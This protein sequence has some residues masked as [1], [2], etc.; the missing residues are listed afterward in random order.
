M[1]AQ[2]ERLETFCRCV[3]TINYAEKLSRHE[4]RGQLDP[5]KALVAVLAPLHSAALCAI[6][7]SY[8]IK[9]VSLLTSLARMLAFI[10]Q[11]HYVM[12]GKLFDDSAD[13]EWNQVFGNCSKLGRQ[14]LRSLQPRSKLSNEM[15]PIVHFSKVL[16]GTDSDMADTSLRDVHDLPICGR[17]GRFPILETSAGTGEGDP[18][19]DSR[20]ELNLFYQLKLFLASAI[21]GNQL[22]IAH[23]VLSSDRL[24]ASVKARV[25]NPPPQNTMGCLEPDFWYGFVNLPDGEDDVVRLFLDL[26]ETQ[27]KRFGRC[28]FPNQHLA[29]MAEVLGWRRTPFS[30]MK[31]KFSGRTMAT[32]EL[33]LLALRCQPSEPRH[34]IASGY[35]LDRGETITLSLDGEGTKPYDKVSL[36]ARGVEIRPSEAGWT[37]LG[38]CAFDAGQSYASVHGVHFTPKECVIASLLSDLGYPDAWDTLGVLVRG[39]AGPV[40]ANDEVT[41]VVAKMTSMPH[42]LTSLEAAKEHLLETVSE[43]EGSIDCFL[44]AVAGDSDTSEMMVP[45]AWVHLGLSLAPGGCIMLGEED[46]DMVKMI[47]RCPGLTSCHRPTDLDCIRIAMWLDEER[48]LRYL[49]TDHPA[50]VPLLLERAAEVLSSRGKRMLTL[51]GEQG[52]SLP[53]HHHS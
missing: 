36:T 47:K 32:K 26:H 37:N 40:V 33:F 12:D 10:P 42:R 24:P 46:D 38:W 50:E 45:W 49:I 15:P 23:L 52:T 29:A 4:A 21:E 13:D 3:W 44:A 6:F 35:Y 1:L 53:C 16:F 28:H 39:Q 22:T 2:T 30:T 19:T 51:N 9:D 5:E 34:W 31:L 11:R 17:V 8:D 27:L 43:M 20:D 25:L 48:T 41:S 7:G 14:R 18:A